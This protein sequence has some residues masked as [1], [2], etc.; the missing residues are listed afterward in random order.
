MDPNAKLWGEGS[1]LVDTRRYQR[2]GGKLIY[3][4]YTRPNIA[5]SISVVSH[6]MHSPYE[7]HLET[8]YT[9]L[10]CLKARP[11]KVSFFSSER[12]VSIFTDADWV[13]S[14][15]ERRSTYRYCTYVWHNV[16][17]WRSKKQGA[18]A[19]NSAE[20]E[21]KA[22]AQCQCIFEGLNSKSP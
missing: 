22:M 5:I 20:A 8:V 2:L 6:F 21:F 14:V 9:I 3:L 16:V 13:G 4:P 1:V 12:N 11:L 19:R 7:E 10:R 17:T 18:V 15:T